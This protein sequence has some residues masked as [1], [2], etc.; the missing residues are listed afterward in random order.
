MNYIISLSATTTFFVAVAFSLLLILGSMLLLSIFQKQ[1]GNLSIGVPVPPFIGAVTT[2]WALSL[3]FV[4]A[5]IW[6]VNARAENWA[7]QERSAIARL[8]G[9]A[10]SDALNSPTLMIALHDYTVAS[11]EHEWKELA[12]REPAPEVDSA[13]QRIR[14]EIVSD[15]FRNLPTALVNKLVNDFDRLQDARDVRLGIGARSINSYKWYLVFS[16]TVLS[17]V[18]IAITH[19]DKPVAGRNAIIIFTLSASV[20]LWILVLHANPYLGVEGILPGEVNI[21]PFPLPEAAG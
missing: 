5:D 11:T 9:T 4:A 3:G 7:S 18:T 6:S 14:V 21:L 16:L 2:V 12:N 17:L 19:A 10:S 1:G 15:T 13:L 8:A 20:S